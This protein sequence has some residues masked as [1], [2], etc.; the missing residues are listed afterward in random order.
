MKII[1]SV[2]GISRIYNA[3]IITNLLNFRLKREDVSWPIILPI[4][5][6][7]IIRFK[8]LRFIFSSLLISSKTGL[9]D[10]KKIGYRKIDRK[11]GVSN[12]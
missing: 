12:K 11:F 6:K 2:I 5:R 10:I 7:E 9:I 3:A 1:E 8:L 4:I